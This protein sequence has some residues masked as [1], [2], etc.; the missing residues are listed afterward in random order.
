MSSSCL[1]RPDAGRVCWMDSPEAP[2]LRDSAAE[3]G[4]RLRRCSPIIP[5]ACICGG[6]IMHVSQMVGRGSAV[7]RLAHRLIIATQPNESR[8][9]RFEP[10]HSALRRNH[11]QL[12]AKRFHRRLIDA[13]DER[14]L[15]VPCRGH[16]KQ[17]PVR[18]SRLSALCRVPRTGIAHPTLFW[19]HQAPSHFLL[20][21][22]FRSSQLLFRE[23]ARSSLRL[24]P[25]ARRQ[26]EC[27]VRRRP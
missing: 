11:K 22:R 9:R 2:Q 8:R 24:G 27:G 18:R 1:S 5:R 19:I 7:A 14:R 12:P 6:E 13:S 26:G 21:K 23:E 25:S 10:R 4:P 20:K 17:L 15:S 3:V 16:E